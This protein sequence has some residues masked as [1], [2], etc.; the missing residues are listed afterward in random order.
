MVEARVHSF[1]HPN[2]RGSG[3]PHTF[4][5]LPS[6]PRPRGC[7]WSQD[8]KF[9]PKSIC[10]LLAI[11]IPSRSSSSLIPSLPLLPPS[12]P[13]SSQLRIDPISFIPLLIFI[14]I[15]LFCLFVCQPA[16]LLLPLL[17]LPSLHPFDKLS[18]SSSSGNSVCLASE[19]CCKANRERWTMCN[20]WGSL[21]IGLAK[22]TEGLARGMEGKG[23]SVTFVYVPKG[24]KQ[25]PSFRSSSLHHPLPSS[26]SL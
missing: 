7:H 1:I 22:F 11:L 26:T 6:P 14:S 13:F 17:P 3:F 16:D 21:A 4:H 9:G 25:H 8:S 2:R 20:D 5:P 19:Y 15:P 12:F 10:A 18:S 24:Q 23:R